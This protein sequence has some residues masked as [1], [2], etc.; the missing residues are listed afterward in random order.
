M[1]FPIPQ[2]G[3]AT[4]TMSSNWHCCYLLNHS[5]WRRLLPQC[6]LIWDWRR[7]KGHVM[8]MSPIGSVSRG[9]RFISILSE[10]IGE[11]FHSYFLSCYFWTCCYIE[12]SNNYR[13]PRPIFVGM[14]SGSRDRTLRLVARTYL[15]ILGVLTHC[16]PGSPHCRY[17]PSAV[18][19]R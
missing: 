17:C 1:R 7:P 18:R 10:V 16:I 3:I 2:M 9:G 14:C 19:Q 4:T 13:M 12:P 5:P 11:L 15:L 6:Q 8:L